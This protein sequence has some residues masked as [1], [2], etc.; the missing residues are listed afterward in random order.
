MQIISDANPIIMLAA[1]I[2]PMVCTEC[3]TIRRATPLILTL[4][5]ARNP[6]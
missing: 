3:D 2:M 1:L 5:F 4:C 6:I